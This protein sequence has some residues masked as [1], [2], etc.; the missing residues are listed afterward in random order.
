MGW[1]RIHLGPFRK[2]MDKYLYFQQLY[3]KII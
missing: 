1:K 3:I 2:K